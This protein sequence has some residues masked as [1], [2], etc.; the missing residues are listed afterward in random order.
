VNNN[1][2]AKTRELFDMGGYCRSWESGRC[3][4]NAGHHI[5]R[6]ISNSPFNYAPLNNAREHMPE[7]RKNLPDI[8]SFEVRKKYLIKTKEYLNEIGYIPTENDLKFLESNK[9]YYETN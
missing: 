8:H 4:A 5:L 9:K 6:R 2:T 3:D 7:G 1:F